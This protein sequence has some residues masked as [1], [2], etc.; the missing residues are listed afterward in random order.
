MI[1]YHP[2][3]VTEL[4][5]VGLPVYY[6][7]FITARETPCITYYEITNFDTVVGETLGYSEIAFQIKVW[8]ESVAEMNKYA[9]EVDK[10]MRPL[11]FK[12]GY[13]T[14]MY[15]ESIGAKI[16]R[17]TARAVEKY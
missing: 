11:G 2:T 7:N 9:A 16:L 8:A 17:Y 10:I 1:V 12:R 5:K 15:E 4:S 13:S 3:L 14:E 6:D